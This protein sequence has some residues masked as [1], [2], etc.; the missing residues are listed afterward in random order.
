MLIRTL[1]AMSCAAALEAIVQSRVAIS[2]SLLA[3]P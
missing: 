1:L 3:R 2:T